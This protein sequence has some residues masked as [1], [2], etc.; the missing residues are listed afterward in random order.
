MGVVV[1][2]LPDDAPL[3]GVVHLRAL[4]GRGTAASTEEMALDSRDVAG[5]ALALL[6]G[7]LDAEVSPDQGIW[8]VT[9]GA[10]VLERDYMRPAAGELAGASLWGIGKAVAREAGDLHPR[11]IDLDPNRPV[12]AS[13]L[14]DEL[15]YPDE[16][17]TLPYRDEQT[18]FGPSGPGR[19]RTYPPIFA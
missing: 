16:E 7:L 5:S 6:Q 4:N 14:A 17:T 2:R 8:F 19:S 3:A 18:P 1:R 9:H 13:L 11:M 10:Q 15:M 12:P